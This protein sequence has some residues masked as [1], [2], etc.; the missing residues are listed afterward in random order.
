MPEDIAVIGYD[1]IPVASAI[2]P[3]L[4]TVRQPVEKMGN[5]AFAIALEAM[6]GKLKGEKKLVFEPELIVRESA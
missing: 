5:E 3:S 6:Q 2:T 4:T 1:G